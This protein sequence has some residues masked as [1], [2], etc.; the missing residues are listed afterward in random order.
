MKKETKQNRIQS[1]NQIIKTQPSNQVT[2]SLTKWEKEL[3][4]EECITGG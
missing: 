2:R 4:P 1:I 3:L